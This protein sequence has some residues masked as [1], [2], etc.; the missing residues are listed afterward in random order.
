[1]RPAVFCKP[2]CGGVFLFVRPVCD[3]EPV[4]IPTTAIGTNVIM[5][6]Q[7]NR[8]IVQRFD[9]WGVIAME[10]LDVSFELYEAGN[11]IG[12]AALLVFV[13]SGI[14]A[15]WPGGLSSAISRRWRRTGAGHWDGFSLCR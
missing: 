1:M 4:A 8:T 14:G 5:T 9:I 10:V 13:L 7:T 11:C 3:G 2:R 12:F 15:G 6:G